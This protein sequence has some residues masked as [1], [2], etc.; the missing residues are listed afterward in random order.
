MAAVMI[1]RK[2][3][4][5]LAISGIIITYF[6]LFSQVHH[7]PYEDSQYAV[8]NLLKHVLQDR[9]DHGIRRNVDIEQ[10]ISAEVDYQND[11]DGH[12]IKTGASV[13]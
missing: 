3:V 7:E 6:I 13:M 1:K 8:K 5:L 9:N 12:V 2:V 10:E 11:I 4:F